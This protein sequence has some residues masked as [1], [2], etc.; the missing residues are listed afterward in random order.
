MSLTAP[1]K[2]HNYLGEYSSDSNALA[3][4]QGAKWDSAGDGTGNPR[5]GMWY[6]DTL[7]HKP[8]MFQNSAW[9][10]IGGGSGYLDWQESVLDRFDP[11]SALPATPANGDRYIATATANGW[12][13]NNIYAYDTT[14]AAWVATVPNNGATCRVEDESTFYV[15]DG[16]AWGLWSVLPTHN[17]DDRYFTETELGGTTASSEGANLIGTDTKTNLNSATTVEAALTDLNGKNPPKRGVNAGN[18]NSTV[19]GAIGDICIDTTNSILY[20]NM[21]GVNTGW[22]VM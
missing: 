10:F 22:V 16:A 7:Y 19:A 5:N 12:T 9:G 13:E 18:P 15:F 11:T 8:K 14:G 3:F 6:Y 20:M 21:T 1:Y 17:H 4:I 2:Q